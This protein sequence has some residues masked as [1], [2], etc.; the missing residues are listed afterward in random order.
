MEHYSLWYLNSTTRISFPSSGSGSPNY[1]TLATFFD[2]YNYPTTETY[3]FLNS[4]VWQPL[5]NTNRFYEIH[6]P[7]LACNPTVQGIFHDYPE[8]TNALTLHEMPNAIFRDIILH[9]GNPA[10][11]WQ[12]LITVVLST[13]YHDWV[14]MFDKKENITTVST[15]PCLLPLYSKGFI[16][17]IANICLHLV[18]M[19]SI[20][21]WFATETEYSLLNRS[22]QV[23]AQ[24]EAPATEKL[25]QDSTMVDDKTIRRRIEANAQPRRRLWVRKTFDGERVCLS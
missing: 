15:V 19:S 25:M 4:L 1:A 10:I 17:S 5:N 23:M 20:T 3:D 2:T 8:D 21:V 11:A 18:L 16:I 6:A 12:A 24:L 13:T 22:W 9:T 14:T 7:C